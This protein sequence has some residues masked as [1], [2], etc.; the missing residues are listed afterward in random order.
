MECQ[1][2]LIIPEKLWEN[3][4]FA[5]DFNIVVENMGLLI[6]HD[7]SCFRKTLSNGITQKYYLIK[8]GILN[9]AGD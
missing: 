7:E 6:V 2:E 3:D 9:E 5:R 1:I 4:N 8:I